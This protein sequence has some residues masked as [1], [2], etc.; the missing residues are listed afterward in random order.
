[1]GDENRATASGKGQEKLE[2]EKVV[3]I[4]QKI[5]EALKEGFAGFRQDLQALA[6]SGHGS[7][8]EF[9]YQGEPQS[10]NQGGHHGSGNNSGKVG[11]PNASMR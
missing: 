3:E 1:M 11:D 6:R 10:S 8:S 2:M 4:L 5:L 9:P 7:P